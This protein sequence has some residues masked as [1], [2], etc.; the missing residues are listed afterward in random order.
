MDTLLEN[1]T[2]ERKLEATKND[3]RTTLDTLETTIKNKTDALERYEARNAQ[4]EKWCA[5]TQERLER[6][7][8]SIEDTNAKMTA[9]TEN[10]WAQSRANFDQLESKLK[11]HDTH[12]ARIA[13]LEASVEH[14]RAAQPPPVD[15]LDIER[16]VDARI[17][18]NTPV[19]HRPRRLRDETPIF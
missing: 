11:D 5:E 18:A 10:Y 17:I 3:F 13:E 7:S 12:L 1:K 9:L 8:R 19:P 14:Y 6:E 2:L 15:P 4:L 16:I